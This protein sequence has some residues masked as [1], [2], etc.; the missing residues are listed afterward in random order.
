MIILV[1]RIILIES[2]ESYKCY[3]YCCSNNIVCGE[4][5]ASRAAKLRACSSA[6]DASYAYNTIL[7]YYNILCYTIQLYCTRL[8]T[9]YCIL[10]TIYYILYTIY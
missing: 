5:R 2:D 9:I 1:I 10:C 3:L 4:G 6:S 8:C 7:L